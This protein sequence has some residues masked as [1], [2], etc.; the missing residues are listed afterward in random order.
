MGVYAIHQNKGS[1]HIFL[2]LDTLI[3]NSVFADNKMIK[4]S[5]DQGYKAGEK[6]N[7]EGK[8]VAFAPECKRAHFIRGVHI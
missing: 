3:N 8:N 7:F 4:L 2:C 5:A 1:C 6:V